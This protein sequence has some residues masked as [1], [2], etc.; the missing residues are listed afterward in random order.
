MQCQLVKLMLLFFVVL[1][2]MSVNRPLKTAR[3]NK[4]FCILMI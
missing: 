3:K 4:A 1:F 2:K